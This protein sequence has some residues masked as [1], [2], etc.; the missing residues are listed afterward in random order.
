MLTNVLK[1]YI[2]VLEATNMLLK[3]KAG[4]EIHTSPQKGVIN[5]NRLSNHTI[6]FKLHS[7]AFYF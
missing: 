5:H 3:I 2:F 6:N 4:A 1:G 7:L